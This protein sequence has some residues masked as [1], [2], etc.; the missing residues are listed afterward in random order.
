[1]SVLWLIPSAVLAIAA[2]ALVRGVSA[3]AHELR[4]LDETAVE[5][6]V[7]LEAMAEAV[8][9]TNSALLGDGTRHRSASGAPE[10]S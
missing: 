2:V 8:A 5:I 6:G 10:G 3:T 9:Q 4:E 7:T 1:M